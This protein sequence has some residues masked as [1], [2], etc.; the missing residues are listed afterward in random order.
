MQKGKNTG[1]ASKVSSLVGDRLDAFYDSACVPIHMR[2][3]LMIY[4]IHDIGNLEYL[5]GESITAL[6][7][8][9]KDGSLIGT[10]V[11]MASKQDQKRYFGAPI[12]NFNTWHF[13]I[14]ERKILEGLSAKSA[15][16]LGKEASRVKE[17]ERRQQ[18]N[19]R[20]RQLKSSNFYSSIEEICNDREFGEGS[21]GR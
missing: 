16:Y 21:S 12:I 19:K 18:N 14:V 10:F 17:Q 1:V 4:G 11:D 8:G 2:N 6:E 13:S 15:V 5:D 7:E 3:L 20:H 9:V